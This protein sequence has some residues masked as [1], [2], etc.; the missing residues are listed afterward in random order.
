M[1]RIVSGTDMTEGMPGGAGSPQPGAPPGN[2]VSI[3]VRSDEVKR[4]VEMLLAV[5]C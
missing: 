3:V 1:G 2:S 4:S 5:L